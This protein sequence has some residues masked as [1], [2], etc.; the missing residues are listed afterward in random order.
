M[1]LTDMGISDYTPKFAIQMATYIVGCIIKESPKKNV[2]VL[3]CMIRTVKALQKSIIQTVGAHK[4]VFVET[5]ARVQGLT[6]DV[7]VLVIPNVSYIRTLE[8]HL[9]NVATS[10]A[11][12]HTIIIADKDIMGYS[13]MDA[14]VRSFI[15]KLSREQMVYVPARLDAK[16]LTDSGLGLLS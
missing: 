7:T 15:E 12:E 11:K 4:N 16:M 6:T 14:E 9:F 8:P 3:T 2:A 1:V 13:T 10:R 5:I